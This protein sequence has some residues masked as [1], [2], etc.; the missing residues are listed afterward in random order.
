ME[1]SAGDRAA[2]I[3]DQLLGAMQHLLR[4]AAGEGQQQNRAGRDAAL[5]QPRDP[6][7][8]RAS[9]AR[10]RARDHQQRALAMGHRFVLRGIEHL[11]VL[12]A[13]VALVIGIACARPLR[14]KRLS[15]RPRRA[16]IVPAS[17]CAR[18]A[19]LPCPA[20]SNRGGTAGGGH[21]QR[22]IVRR[23][24]AAGAQR[25]VEGVLPIRPGRRAHAGI[26]RTGCVLIRAVRHASNASV[27]D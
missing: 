24:C 22:G 12:D 15:C 8:Q 2:P 9:L 11:G 19:R 20:R 25:V 6:I 26:H 27:A 1:R 3:A 14:A 18:D 16:G 4:R 21:V 13:E 17:E 5:D 7:N 10:A 23:R